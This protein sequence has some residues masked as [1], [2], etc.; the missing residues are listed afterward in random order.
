[1]MTFLDHLQPV[2]KSIRSSIGEHDN[3]PDGC[4]YSCTWNWCCPS[5]CQSVSETFGTSASKS[6]GHFSCP[7]SNMFLF[8]FPN[9]KLVLHTGDFR[10]APHLLANPLLQ[11]NQIDTVYLD[12]TSVP[13]PSETKSSIRCS[14]LP[15]FQLLWLPLSISVARWSD[16]KYCWTGFRN[17]ENQSENFDCGGSLSHWQRTH[18]S[19]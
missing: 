7:G 1:M 17:V 6:R 4:F 9:G 2:S 8:R 15:F 10:A 3:S 12:T 19:R 14:L 18:L 5:G 13:H 16:R 11:P